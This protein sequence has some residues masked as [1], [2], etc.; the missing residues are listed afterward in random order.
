M[1]VFIAFSDADRQ[2][3]QTVASALRG[4]GYS[5]VNPPPSS[6]AGETRDSGAL[7]KADF[8]VFLITPDAVVAGGRCLS[9]LFEFRKRWRRPKGRIL[10]IVACTTPEIPKSISDLDPVTSYGNLPADVLNSIAARRAPGIRARRLALGAAAIAA[11]GAGAFFFLNTEPP[12]P[13]VHVNPEFAVTGAD[14]FVYWGSKP[15]YGVKLDKP[16]SLNDYTC[17]LGAPT[18]GNIVQAT[19]DDERCKKISVE[20]APGP[21]AGVTENGFQVGGTIPYTILD[22]GGREVDRGAVELLMSNTGMML[23]L[24]GVERSSEI[25]WGGYALESGTEREIEVL[26]DGEQLAEPHQ[27][28]INLPGARVQRIGNCR[29]KL[30]AS[31]AGTMEVYVTGKEDQPKLFA[32]FEISLK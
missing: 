15:V 25:G 9:E 23:R 6:D 5:V 4:E 1:H 28:D 24:D 17:K 16:G 29:F 30:A 19:A 11:V 14:Q 26:N 20:L 31:R 10:P 22:E 21:Y 27:C 3:T 8:L 7:G 12:A 18:G 32:A 2:I 13:A